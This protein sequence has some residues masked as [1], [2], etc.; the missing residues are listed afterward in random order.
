MPEPVTFHN[1]LGDRVAL[2]TGAGA[3]GDEIGIGRAIALQLAGEGAKLGCL[4]LDLDRAEATAQM[5]NSRG[6]QAIALG[7]D[8]TRMADCDR[9]VAA[10][11]DAFGTIDVLVNNVG[12]AAPLTLDTMDLGLWNKIIDTNLTAAMLMCRAA[13]PAMAQQGRG[14]I[15]NISSIAGIRAMGSLAYG[16]S[17]AALAH[18]SRELAL[19]HGRQGIRVNTI[20]PGHMA[21]PMAMRLLPTE[22]Q[23]KRRKVGPL[24]IDGDA[25]DIARAVLFLASDDARFIT[26]AELPVDGGVTIIAP[27]AGAALLAD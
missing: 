12:I 11:Q 10:V 26:G 15:I 2:V 24:G 13:I 5:I 6:G 23:E 7:G 20:A 27:L 19:M 22:M 8:V 9:V 1:R 21:T 4:D 17:K 16:S 18:L 14:S 3:E 25:W